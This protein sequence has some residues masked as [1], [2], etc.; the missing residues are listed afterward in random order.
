MADNPLTEEDL[1]QMQEREPSSLPGYMVKAVL[2]QLVE[3]RWLLRTIY[4][5]NKRGLP[6]GVAE[7]IEGVLWGGGK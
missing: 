5:E 4:R 1:W 6:E 3:S 2:A 7:R